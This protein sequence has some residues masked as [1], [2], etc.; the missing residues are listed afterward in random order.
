MR[1]ARFGSPIPGEIG[2][3]ACSKAAASPEPFQPA[4]AAPSPACSGGTDRKT[5]FRCH[6]LRQRSRRGAQDRRP[7]RD[8]H[9]RRGRRGLAV[10]RTGSW[11]RRTSFLNHA[12]ALPLNALAQMLDAS[13]D[14]RNIAQIAMHD[15]PQFAFHHRR[16]VQGLQVGPCAPALSLGRRADAHAIQD[17]GQSRR[18]MVRSHH[19]T[20]RPPRDFLEAPGP[21]ASRAKH[22]NSRCIRELAAFLVLR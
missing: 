5:L 4:I 19:D 13:P 20:G 8:D 14:S 1:K 17:G 12:L 11:R 16:T 21:R 6:Q 3:F 18:Q 7:H 15:Q 2:S 22:C 9:R 10:T